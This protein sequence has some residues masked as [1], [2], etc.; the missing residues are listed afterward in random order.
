MTRS[1]ETQF[2]SD[3]TEW[4]MDMRDADLSDQMAKKGILIF[5]EKHYLD[6]DFIKQERKNHVATIRERA[7]EK[8]RV[9]NG[10]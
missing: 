7:A 6:A 4:E 5:Y 1:A 2:K 8:E 9:A 3:P 10:R